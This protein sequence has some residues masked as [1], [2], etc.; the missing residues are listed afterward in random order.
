MSTS[1]EQAAQIAAQHGPPYPPQDQGL[2]QTP[3]PLPDAPVCAVFLLGF[4]LAGAA[5]MF[6][7]KY[8]ARKGRKFVICGMLFGFCF[9]RIF[10]TTCRIAWSFYPKNVRIG[11]AAQVA[12]YAGIILLFLANLFF[13][14][15][16]VRAQHPHI[17]W[18]KPFTIAFPALFVII[19]ATILCLIVG[20]IYSFFT[21]NEDSL[22][23]V[24]YIQLYGET[25][26]AIVAFLPIPIVL[27]SSIA[28]RKASV[29][30]TKPID[31]FG[32][33]SMR[34]KVAMVLVSAIFLD[35]GACWRCATLYLPI[36]YT[37][38]PKPWYFSKT[39][40]YLFNFTIEWCVVATWAAMR[41]DKR[42][43]IP[44]GA[45]GPFSYGG[46][47][48]FAGEPGNEKI[49]LGNRDSM[50]HLTGSQV[51]GFQ[52]MRTSWGA[53]RTSLARDSR[54]SWGGLSRD[55]VAAGLAEDGVKIMPYA[56]FGGSTE[57]VHP[58]HALTAADVGIE[59]VEAE[60]GWDAKSGKWALRPVSHVP[61]AAVGLTISRPFLHRDSQSM[62]SAKAE[63]KKGDDSGTASPSASTVQTY[64]PVAQSQRASEEKTI[65]V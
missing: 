60:M 8:N 35:L 43:Y 51:S 38:D 22:R 14:Q 40:F 42:F 20:V 52:S 36:H 62:H 41:I 23:A 25:L 31:K 15:R 65:D 5:H 57:N 53:S 18:S 44:D 28:R 27:A 7:L 2:G 56:S 9:T 13:T 19:V 6:L 16:I 17:G 54:I 1:Q 34:T 10:A 50:R 64:T 59:G 37:V 63:S 29:L 39:C 55:D 49:A 24:H 47:F 21:L 61:P 26:Y 4:I 45:K 48:T 33:G 46:G 32:S 30:N 11:I 12:V 3:S 58:A